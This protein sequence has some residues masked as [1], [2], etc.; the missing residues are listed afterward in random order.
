MNGGFPAVIGGLWSKSNSNP[1][2]SKTLPS[3]VRQRTQLRKGTIVA[4]I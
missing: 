2:R 3:V 1:N 4:Y